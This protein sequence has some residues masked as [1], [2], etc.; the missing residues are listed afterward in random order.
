[1][2]VKQPRAFQQK[3][4]KQTTK[5]VNTHQTASLSHLVAWMRPTRRA[6]TQISALHLGFCCYCLCVWQ[7]FPQPQPCCNV[8]NSPFSLF[9]SLSAWQI[10]KLRSQFLRLLGDESRMYVL[11][12][13]VA[14]VATSTQRHGW[15]ANEFQ[16][17]LVW[18][19]QISNDV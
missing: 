6:A 10:R 7:L 19:A 16:L 4:S 1:M 18:V 13:C 5:S 15:A 17:P 9:A 8:Y 14:C 3:P 2:C 11:G 12:R